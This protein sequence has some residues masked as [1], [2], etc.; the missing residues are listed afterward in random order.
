LALKIALQRSLGMRV[1]IKCRLLGRVDSLNPQ[2]VE[3]GDKCVIGAESMLLAHGPGFDQ[4]KRTAIGDYTYIGYRVTILPGVSIGEGC[5]IGA[6]SIVTRDIPPGKVAAGNPA[7]VLRDV[8]PEERADIRHR[9]DN[10]L[11]FG[12]TGTVT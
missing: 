11:F 3:I 5:I 1:G 6:G 8:R 2:L 7:R 9:M 4:Q 12:K 10:D